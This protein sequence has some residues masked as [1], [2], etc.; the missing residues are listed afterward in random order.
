MWLIETTNNK[1]WVENLKQWFE[2]L[3]IAIWSIISLKIFV[4]ATLEKGGSGGLDDKWESVFFWVG[5]FELLRINVH[6]WGL[7]FTSNTSQDWRLYVE[8]DIVP[9]SN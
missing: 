9:L 7:K 2:H 8:K 3:N 6:N 1:M 5:E 4:Y